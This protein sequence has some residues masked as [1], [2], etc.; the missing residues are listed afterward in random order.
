MQSRAQLCFLF[1]V[2]VLAAASMWFYVQ[3]ILI[4]Y[5]RADAATN[6]RPRGNLSD[7]YPRW[8]GARELLL[9]RRN[10]YSDEI[11][12]EIQKGY[13]GRELD[14]ARPNDPKDQQ[15]FAYP[16]YVVFLL[17]PLIAL[18]FNAVQ[19]FC[20][21]L[22]LLLTAG[23]IC[24][25]LKTLRWSLSPLGIATAVALTLGSF[26]AVQGIKLQ[27]LSLLV[28]GMLAGSAACVAGGFLFF[29][30]ALLA[31]TT[32]K[33]QLAWVFVAWLL[34]WA[35]S[36]WRARRRLVYGF[37]AVMLLQ[38]GG[39]EILL[40]GWWRMFSHA[41]RQY[42]Q[43]TQNQSVLDQLV[44]WGF[45][46]KLLALV[47]VL[48][49]AL[50]LWKLRGV[51]ADAIEFGRAAALVMALTVLIV[52]MYAPYNQVLLI[53]AILVLARDSTLLTSR[54]RAH[55]FGY[56]V[57]ACTLAWQWIASLTLSVAYLFVSPA[58]ALGRWKWPFYAT[59][60]LPL[61][62]FALVF[63]DVRNAMDMG[64]V[65][66]RQGVPRLQSSGESRH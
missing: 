51:A 14:A 65:I 6:E 32:V 22:L 21:C 55:R 31:L 16:L 58:F 8:L 3:R 23:S 44:P 54:S 34:L 1:L 30:G 35:V 63:I 39:A 26:P 42:H 10:P 38:L 18:P 12:L 43:Y 59:F 5:E 24:L 15:A 19:M 60:A 27:Q 29:G 45:V 57:G 9:H 66:D 64:N 33:P 25:W 7:L 37:G 41:L 48:A 11:T 28:A 20:Y 47:A 61:V 62:A 50:V 49:S 36:D 13:Y 17:A 56:V 52:P 2:A 4:P 46:G 40:P 53:P